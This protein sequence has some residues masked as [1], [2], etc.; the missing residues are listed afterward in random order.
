MD[1][2]TTNWHKAGE[3]CVVRI[4]IVCTIQQILLG[5]MNSRRL[6]WGNV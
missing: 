3:E 4:V 1:L 5:M 2:N 6:T